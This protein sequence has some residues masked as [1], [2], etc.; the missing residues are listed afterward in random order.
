MP[1]QSNVDF[2]SHNIEYNDGNGLNNGTGEFTATITGVYSFDI[3]YCARRTG[4]S[5]LFKNG[6]LYETLND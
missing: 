2:L 6:N 5:M 4:K 1:F 3:K